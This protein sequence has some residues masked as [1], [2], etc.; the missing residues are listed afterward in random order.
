MFRFFQILFYIVTA[1]WLVSTL[2]GIHWIAL[3]VATTLAGA[4]VTVVYM[5]R[6][7]PAVLVR[8]TNGKFWRGYVDC[9]SFLTGQP[10]CLDGTSESRPSLKLQSVHDFELASKR[11]KQAVR[12]HDDV[13]DSMLSR[14]HE[15]LTLR[16]SRKAADQTGPLASFLLA[17]PEGIGKRYLSRVVAKLLYGSAQ[18]EVYDCGKLTRESLLGTVGQ[19]GKLFDIVHRTPCVMLLFENIERADEG[20]ATAIVQLLTSGKL[21]PPGEAASIA[22]QQTTVVLT[23]CRSA[24]PN[25]ERAPET[26]EPQS[27]RSSIEL[28]TS[29]IQID[30]RIAEAVTEVCLLSAPND[31]VKAEVVALLMQKECRDH[32][33]TLSK[34][35][36]EIL[37]VQVLQIVE[38][39]GFQFVPQRIQKL[40]RKPLM[41]A[42]ENDT[43]SLSLRI[44]PQSPA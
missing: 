23:S 17:G 10:R 19:K 12:G 2:A 33:V 16:K 11:A 8:L 14:L 40:V 42:T 4:N 37:A 32:G 35:A 9:V 41:E 3:L 31:L 44:R 20:V 21:I 1:W 25:A 43:A 6:E 38:G 22:F 15:N 28:V 18:V 7:H 39:E 27:L 5:L 13:I 26:R 36:P 30:A 29:E 34:V 24:K